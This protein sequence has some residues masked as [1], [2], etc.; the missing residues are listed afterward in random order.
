MSKK[1]S[2]ANVYFICSFAAIGED[3]F[4]IAVSFFSGVAVSVA[5]I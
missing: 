3:S 2:A 4:A 5:Y 1:T